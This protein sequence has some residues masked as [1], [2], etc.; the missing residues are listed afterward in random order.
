MKHVTNNT[1]D[2]SWSRILVLT[3]LKAESPS[4]WSTTRA[5]SF[6]WS[7][8]HCSQT[9]VKSFLCGPPHWSTKAKSLLSPPDGCGPPLTKLIQS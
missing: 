9:K 5:K 6:L 7:S 4:T 8:P 2:F 3:D 1:H